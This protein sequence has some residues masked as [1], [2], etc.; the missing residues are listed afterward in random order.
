MDELTFVE[1]NM[2]F[3][4]YDPQDCFQ[5]EKSEIYKKIQNGIKIAEFVLY[6]NEQGIPTIFIVE[7]KSNAPTDIK[8]YCSEIELKLSNSLLL[9]LSLFHQRHELPY[10]SL[11]NSLAELNID[12]TEFK[13]ILIIN[14]FNKKHLPPITELLQSNLKRTLKLWHKSQVL[15]LNHHGALS[16]GLI[17]GQIE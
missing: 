5:I 12:I 16:R 13:F 8:Q 2:I 14:N 3:G 9:F 17:S 1:S 6:R 4:P 10:F 15:V 11:P 7:A